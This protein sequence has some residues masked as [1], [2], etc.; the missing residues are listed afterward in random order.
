MTWHLSAH[1]LQGARRQRLWL[2]RSGI[3]VFHRLQL[4]RHASAPI[5]GQQAQV[6]AADAGTKLGKAGGII[7]FGGGCKR[8][9]VR[10][11]TSFKRTRNGMAPGPRGRL[12]NHR[13]RGP[14]AM[15]LRAA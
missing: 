10:P 9:T 2:Q 4:Q 12:V 6:V 13:P 7:A 11:N 15:P 8:S 3:D 14:G 1:L 5:A